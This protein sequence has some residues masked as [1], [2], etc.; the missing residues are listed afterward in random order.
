MQR[1]RLISAP[2]AES[3]LATDVAVDG[4]TLYL[5]VP[6]TGIVTHTFTADPTLTCG[7]LAATAACRGCARTP[8]RAGPRRAGRSVAVTWRQ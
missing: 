2:D 6:G 3:F 8:P 1:E 5:L 4:A 7:A